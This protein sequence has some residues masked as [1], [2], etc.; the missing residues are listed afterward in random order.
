MKTSEIAVITAGALLTA[1]TVALCG[2]ICKNRKKDNDDGPII[3]HIG[4]NS[5]EPNWDDDDWDGTYDPEFD[6]TDKAADRGKVD[7]EPEHLDPMDIH[8]EINLSQATSE[9]L[10]DAVRDVMTDA[11]LDIN[12]DTSVTEF[13]TDVTETIVTGYIESV[14]ACGDKF[15]CTVDLTDK[16][17]GTLT[18]RFA[19]GGKYRKTNNVGISVKD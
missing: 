9:K 4:G 1:G 15:E 14:A 18:T 7:S 10:A 5:A 17:N 3:P 12:A 2:A 6:E 11:E 8:W 16:Y 19:K 13:I